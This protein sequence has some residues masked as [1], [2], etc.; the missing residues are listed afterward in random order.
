LAGPYLLTE[1]FGYHLKPGLD[2][3]GA[4]Y[5]FI[6]YIKSVQIFVQRARE[7]REA[8]E[9]REVREVREDWG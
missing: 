8:R 6:N 4:H 3:L 5:W 7:V 9:A 1:R 2:L